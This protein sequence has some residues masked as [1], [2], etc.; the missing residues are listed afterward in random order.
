MFTLNLN[1]NDSKERIAYEYT[2]RLIIKKIQFLIV[3]NILN[4]TDYGKV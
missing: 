3:C 2:S 4:A 1:K